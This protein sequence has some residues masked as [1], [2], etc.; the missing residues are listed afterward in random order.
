ME[1][2][3]EVEFLVEAIEFLES[4][5]DKSREKII[6]KIVSDN[7]KEVNKKMHKNLFSIILFV[8]LL[9]SCNFQ[10][11][12]EAGIKYSTRP[13]FQ[14]L[15]NIEWREVGLAKELINVKEK[16]VII[17]GGSNPLPLHQWEELK[18]GF[19]WKKNIDRHVLINKTALVRSPNANSNCNR[20]DCLIEIENKG[21][22]WIELA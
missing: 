22:S 4:L 21:Y 12:K 14:V 16:M 19:P 13:V 20:T 18:V 7:L 11:T 8:I 2:K 5:D 9:N 17:L 15:K 6:Y 10:T 3:F 1:K